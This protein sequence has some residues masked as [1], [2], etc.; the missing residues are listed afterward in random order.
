MNVSHLLYLLD[1]A[2]LD[3]SEKVVRATNDWPIKRVSDIRKQLW[4][5]LQA[6]SAAALKKTDALDPFDFVASAS[7]RGE[8]GC[9]AWD[10]RIKKARP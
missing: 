7:M 8:D 3:T 6:G 2:G 10:C 4:E 5:I 9:F 1:S